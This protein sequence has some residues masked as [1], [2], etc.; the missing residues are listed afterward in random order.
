V[1]C[2]LSEIFIVT[3][4]GFI[5]P[6]ATL[7][8]LQILFLNMVTDIFPAL[9]LGVGKGDKTIMDN[10]PRN[11]SKNIITNKN[12]IAIALYSAAIT[13][14]VIIAV[15]YCKAYLGVDDKVANNIAFITLAFAQLFHVLNM[16]SPHSKLLV[17]EVTTNKFVW[18]AILICT[19]LMLLVYAVPQIHLVLGLVVLPGNVW[20]VAVLAALLPLLLVQLY[21]IIWGRNA[22]ETT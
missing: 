15:F 5:A 12:W 8:P 18:L 10:P 21:K 3:A 13:L 9:A 4:L 19:G 7:L 17:N 6:A 14:S 11:S 2:N 16:S 22:R 20:L 1:S